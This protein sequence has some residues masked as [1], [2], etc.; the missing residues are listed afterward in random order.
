MLVAME[1]VWVVSRQPIYQQLARF[2]S[3]IF[4][5]RF[6]MGAATGG[7][8]MEFQFGTNWGLFTLRWRCFGSMLAAEGLFAFFLESGALA[9]CCSAGI[10]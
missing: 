6:E 2:W 4:G 3:R 1:S 5:L 8:V 7:I 10:A 9:W